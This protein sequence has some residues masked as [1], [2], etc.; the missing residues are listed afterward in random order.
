MCVREE[1]AS[2][3]EL[4]ARQ[5]KQGWDLL[6]WSDWIVVPS[7]YARTLQSPAVGVQMGKVHRLAHANCAAA[8]CHCLPPA[9]PIQN[10]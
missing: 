6:G 9:T 1:F 7:V 3:L 10:N 8:P 4:F 2:Y 5:T